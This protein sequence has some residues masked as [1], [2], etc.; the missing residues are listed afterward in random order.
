[1]DESKVCDARVL[2]AIEL[3]EQLGGDLRAMAE[4]DEPLRIR[5]V[6]AAAA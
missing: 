2:A 4:I 6:T 1:V 5:L 3:L